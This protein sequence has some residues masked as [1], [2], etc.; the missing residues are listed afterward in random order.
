MESGR[1]SPTGGLSH[2]SRADD[3]ASGRGRL[4]TSLRH[5]DTVESWRTA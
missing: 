4:W 2:A 3:E 1:K 5:G